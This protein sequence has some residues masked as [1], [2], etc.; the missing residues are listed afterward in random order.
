MEKMTAKELKDEDIISIHDVHKSFFTKSLIAG[1]NEDGTHDLYNNN[2]AKLTRVMRDY[3]SYNQGITVENYSPEGVAID[4]T[5]KEKKDAE[6][7][8]CKKTFVGK[9]WS[10]IIEKE[11]AIRRGYRVEY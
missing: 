6:L 9:N 10:E 11:D 8:A 7:N 5:A 4:M 3:M 2:N 1:K